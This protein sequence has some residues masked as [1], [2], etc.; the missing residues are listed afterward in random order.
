MLIYY[1]PFTQLSVTVSKT[2][3]H[4]LFSIEASFARTG[5]RTV[6]FY[7][8]AAELWLSQCQPGFNRLQARSSWVPT[9]WL[10]L[11]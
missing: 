3:R 11:G 8:A 1:L 4:R 6:R 7:G 9:A 5:D 10:Q 2:V